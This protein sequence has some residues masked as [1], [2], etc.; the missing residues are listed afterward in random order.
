MTPS[1]LHAVMTTGF[2][3][4]AGSVFA[5]YISFGACPIYLLSASVMSAP[6]SL[7]CSKILYPETRVS[8][9]ARIEDLHLS[10][11]KES[12]ALECISNGAVMAVELVVAIV[13]NLIVFL[14]ILAFVNSVISFT[15]SMIGHEGWSFEVI[16]GY[17]FFPLAY[18]MGITADTQETMR[19]AE[20]MG[21][22]TVLNEFISY[23]KLGEMIDEGKLSVSYGIDF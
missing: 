3:C 14:A 18:I 13:A 1:E 6:G 17:V 7:A 16:M 12:N 19:V 20:L 4:I 21:I 5:A 10:R 2:S 15:G 11:S 22:K 9:L 8:K 23:Q